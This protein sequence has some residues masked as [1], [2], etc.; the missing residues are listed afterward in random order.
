MNEIV[1]GLVEAGRLILTLDA[2]LIEI[3]LRSLQVTVTAVVI[4]AAFGM[5]LGAWLAVRISPPPVGHR[6]AQCLDGAAAGGCR[7]IRLSAVVAGRTFWGFGPAVHAGGDDHRP[8]DDPDTADRLNRASGH[9]CICG[10]NITT[11]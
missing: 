5:P 7:L 6:R 4:A 3:S 11:F 9:A 10:P 8:G 1:Q 2:D